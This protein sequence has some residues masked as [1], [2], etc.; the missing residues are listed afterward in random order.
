MVAEA[1][2]PE[3]RQRAVESLKREQEKQHEEE[4]KHYEEEDLRA[5]PVEYWRTKVNL[6][7]VIS[8]PLMRTLRRIREI[9]L[10]H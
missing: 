8:G 4:E 10:K 5:Y 3:F 6:G 2:A 7:L 9:S 1:R